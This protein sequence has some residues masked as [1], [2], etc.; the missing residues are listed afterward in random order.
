MICKYFLI[1]QIAFLLIVFFDE[2]G[3][4]GYGSIYLFLL[5]L[6]LLLYQ[7]IVKSV[8]KPS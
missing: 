8:M 3:F 1:L 6:L 7:D 2:Q 4:F 5:L